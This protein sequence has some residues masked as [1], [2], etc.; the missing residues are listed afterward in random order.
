M[1][2]AQSAVADASASAMANPVSLPVSLAPSL[3]SLPPWLTQLSDA[4]ATLPPPVLGGSDPRLSFD[5]LP[6][7]SQWSLEKP[8]GDL[9][10][11]FGNVE[12]THDDGIADDPLCFSPANAANT[13]FTPPVSSV[14]SSAC[15][16]PFELEKRPRLQ[17]GAA[18]EEPRADMSPTSTTNPLD[19]APAFDGA[20]AV[21]DLQEID[22]LADALPSMPESEYA[23]FVATLLA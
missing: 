16:S 12:R 7:P 22:L 19:A 5:P 4:N 20:L 10:T 1:G 6:S 13:V 17:P 2:C 8:L 15:V 3:A 11:L 21:E 18:K 23:A 9:T 14:L